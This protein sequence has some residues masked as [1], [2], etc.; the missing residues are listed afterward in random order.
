MKM[1]RQARAKAFIAITRH[2]ELPRHFLWSIEN[3]QFP[4]DL[5]CSACCTLHFN[6]ADAHSAI[7]AETLMHYLRITSCL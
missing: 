1:S 7:N 2:S 4:F 5:I 6:A 3:K